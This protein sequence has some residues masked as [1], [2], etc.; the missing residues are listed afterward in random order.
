[1]SPS[2]PLSP[3]VFAI[4]SAL[5]EDCTGL[6]YELREL[7][8]LA[9]RASGRA[10]ERGFES[11]LDYYYFLRYDPAR[12]AELSLLVE[13]L[14][15]NETYF[16]REVSPLNVLVRNFLPKLMAQGIRPR[17]W[18]AACSTGEEPL[19]L[20]MLLDEAGL[21]ERTTI[22]A[23]DIS[24]RTLTHAKNGVFSATLAARAAAG[25][26][27]SLAG[28]RRSGGACRAAHR[29]GRDLAPRQSD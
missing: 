7:D 17:V 1:M 12:E 29:T 13:A 9:E 26:S 5:I 11:L 23:S 16:F 4:L 2:L 28:R 8:L 10:V 27:R 24:A 19:T 15:V 25:G 18:C 6:H 21:L 14:V 3:Q 22:V 20:A